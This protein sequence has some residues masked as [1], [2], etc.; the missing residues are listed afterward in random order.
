MK[1]F[2]MEIFSSYSAVDI[3]EHNHTHTHTHTELKRCIPKQHHHSMWEALEVVIPCYLCI[4]I[5]CNF[6]KYL[7]DKHHEQKVILLQ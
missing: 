4:V 5:S 1:Q 2:I 3:T 6:S 7:E